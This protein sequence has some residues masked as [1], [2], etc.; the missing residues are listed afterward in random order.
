MPSPATD[1]DRILRAAGDILMHDGYDAVTVPRIAKSAGFPVE[2]IDALYDGAGDILVAMLNRE[3]SSM[4]AGIVDHIERDPRGG[5]LSRI[6]LYVLSA[7]YERP[8]AKTLF[9]ID[10]DALNRIMRGSHS[11]SYV[12]Q[13]GVRS[14]MISR[15]QEVGMVRPDVDAEMVSHVLSVY[16]AGLAITAPHDDLDIV[17]RGISELLA[18]GVDATVDDTM[19]GKSV[20]FDWAT[21][22]TLP[23][24]APAEE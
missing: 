9:V 3:F 11:F 2:E 18:R 1:V 6:Y 22:L 23:K 24:P 21:S 4:Y 12:P 13:V 10:R 14:E 20:F 19:P 7:I 15:L 16:S 5:L 17:I 8:L